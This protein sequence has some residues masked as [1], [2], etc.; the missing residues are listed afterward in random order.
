V[1]GEILSGHDA[2]VVSKVGPTGK[3]VFI[4]VYIL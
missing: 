2:V 1:E 3:L 4:T